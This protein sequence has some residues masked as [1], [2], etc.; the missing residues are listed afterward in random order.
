MEFSTELPAEMIEEICGKLDDRS[1][2]RFMETSKRVHNICYDMYLRRQEEFE[3]MK[4]QLEIISQIKQET[5]DL[6]SIVYTNYSHSKA[7]L[8]HTHHT[9]LPNLLQHNDYRGIYLGNPKFIYIPEV[10]L[11][12][13]PDE[14]R[15]YLQQ[16]GLTQENIDKLMRTAIKP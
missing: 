15:F 8:F 6:V 12:G 14:I 5:Y 16:K 13:K 2:S 11:L 10:K 7:H 4:Q 9:S 3:E 1:L